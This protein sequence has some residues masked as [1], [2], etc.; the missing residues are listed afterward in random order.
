MTTRSSAVVETTVNENWRGAYDLLVTAD[1]GLSR[2]AENTGGLIEQNFASLTGTGGVT[3]Q[4]IEDI[5]AISAVE[6]AAPLAFIGQLST[7]SYDVIVGASEPDG[8]KSTFFSQLRGFDVSI[9]VDTHDGVTSI[10]LATHKAHV[11]TSPP[12]T[13]S[14]DDLP[15]LTGVMDDG[16]VQG[17]GMADGSGTWTVDYVAPALPPLSAGLIAVDPHAE[18][19]LLS[20]HQDLFATLGMFD[21]ALS[22]GT[23]PAE[24]AKILQREVGEEAVSVG[25][26]FEAFNNLTSLDGDA[27]PLLVSQGAYPQVTA[28][29][30]ATERLIGQNF[31][32][33]HYDA[34]TRSVGEGWRQAMARAPQGER[35][36]TEYDFSESLTA[37][38]AP[39][40]H[41]S[42]P[43]ASEA[44]G[45]AMVSTTPNYDSSLVGRVEY[46]AAPQ[47]AGDSPSGVNLALR[48][49]PQGVANVGNAGGQ[50][51]TY[52][53]KESSGISF[54][55]APVYAPLGVFNPHDLVQGVDEASYVP[56]G[57]YRST[58]ITVVGGEHDGST[59]A[60][61]FSGRGLALSTP[62]AITTMAAA[63][64]LQGFSGADVVRVRVA[65]VGNYSPQAL[66]KIGDVAGTI[67]A[68]GLD[69]RVVAGSS[70]DQ[71]AV[72]VPQYNQAGDLGWT[73]EE[74]TSLGAAL[75]VEQA[76][77]LATLTLLI[78]TLVGVA[79]LASVV[80]GAGVAKRRDEAA[81][82]GSFGW[83]QPRIRR[84][85]FTED[86]PSLTIVAVAAA[87]AVNTAH[88]GAA[89]TTI[90]A[91]VGTFVAV[92]CWALWSITRQSSTRTH[93]A[94][95]PK[96]PARTASG[97]GSRIARAHGASTVLMGASLV[98]LT[99]TG[100]AF[101][102]VILNSRVS[103]GTSRIAVLVQDALVLPQTILALVGLG[104]GIFMFVN[105]L[106]TALASGVGQYVMLVT[107]GWDRDMLARC[108]RGHIF[109][110]L[111]PGCLM[112]VVGGIS[113]SFIVSTTNPLPMVVTVLAMCGIALGVA[114]LWAGNFA[115]K[116]STVKADK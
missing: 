16:D 83:T 40:L 81:L 37:F 59:L 84:W 65:G 71:V 89:R 23:E 8:A 107:S 78:V 73:V 1:G 106:K 85:F 41:V 29:L 63:N 77:N 115:S 58:G 103:A 116:I 90:I 53:L 3:A 101:L 98:V 74:W 34:E 39:Q 36:E 68:L 12:A 76:Q 69:V 47:S 20:S 95:P 94:R 80:Q 108:V 93:V 113:A 105:A 52:R 61:S 5:A 62:G 31:L 99:L 45:G 7:P 22:G 18:A 26:Y 75:K 56:L 17:I 44:S 35:S 30:Q 21:S 10:P 24:L 66:E 54:S 32:T 67:T 19:Q 55:P 102:A 114:S 96:L 92:V 48:A 88:I 87:Y 50:E 46:D 97:I 11:V 60:P 72:Y 43:G 110:A 82:L 86:L 38:A 111:T 79:L 112:A 42:L 9:N 2:A 49:H 28:S 57:T 109:T 25:T 104:A 4:Q 33:N 70:L 13:G 27:L 14:E 6:V 15:L 51:Q 91:V 100:V 64:Q